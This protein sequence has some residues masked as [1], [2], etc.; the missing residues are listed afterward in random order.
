LFFSFILRDLYEH[1]F[2]NFSGHLSFTK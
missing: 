1:D 2:A